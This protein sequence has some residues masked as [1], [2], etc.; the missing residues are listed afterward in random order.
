[1]NAKKAILAARNLERGK[2]AKSQIV[3]ET[4]KNNT[5]AAELNRS[6]YDSVKR[7]VASMQRL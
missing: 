3:A 5:D 2:T 7:C 6:S 1:M 4:K